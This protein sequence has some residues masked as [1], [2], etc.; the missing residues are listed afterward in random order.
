MNVITSD[1][2]VQTSLVSIKKSSTSWE[3]FY[4]EFYYSCCLVVSQGGHDDAF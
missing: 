2:K 3:D 4:S 1:K